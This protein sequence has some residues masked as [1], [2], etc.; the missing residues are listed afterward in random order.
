MVW[1]TPEFLDALDPGRSARQSRA[2]VQALLH[3]LLAPTESSS[4]TPPVNVVAGKQGLRLFVLVP[5][6]RQEDISVSIEEDRLHL[7]G[8][9]RGPAQ[10]GEEA[11]VIAGF[12]RSIRL[13]FRPDG[14]HV[15]AAIKNGL[16]ELFLPVPLAD[17][18][19]TIP[20]IQS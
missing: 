14:Q 8:E 18:P 5:G 20:I 4:P 15:R 10:E 9:R 7:R 13:P 19:R 16:L 2:H 17:Q 1:Y 3:S 12:D 11:K 6:Y